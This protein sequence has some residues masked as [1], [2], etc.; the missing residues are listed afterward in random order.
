[1]IIIIIL[2]TVL[3]RTVLGRKAKKEAAPDRLATH[4]HEYFTVTDALKI[5]NAITREPQALAIHK[6]RQ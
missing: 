6:S 5:E 3:G 1:M 4:E 2:I